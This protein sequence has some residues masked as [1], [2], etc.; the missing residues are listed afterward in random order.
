MVIREWAED[1]WRSMQ[2]GDDLL[3]WVTR[4]RGKQAPP[5][6]T[7]HP[8]PPFKRR[9]GYDHAEVTG[10]PYRD[11][12]WIKVTGSGSWEAGM[13]R[14]VSGYSPTRG[15]VSRGP[16]AWISLDTYS[17]GIAHWWART[18]P[19]LFARIALEAPA[20]ATWAWGSER[21]RKMEDPRWLPSQVKPRRRKNQKVRGHDPR[22]DWLCEGWWAIARH[23]R[24]IKIQ[25]EHWL[26]NYPASARTHARKLGWDRALRGADGGRILAAL[27]RMHN[28]GAAYRRVRA[29]KK[30]S[31]SRRPMEIL[32]TAYHLPKDKGG[33]GKPGRWKKLIAWSEF[34]GPAPERL[35]S[36][37][38]VLTATPR[39]TDGSGVVFPDWLS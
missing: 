10:W 28:S 26:G 17:V 33:Y 31:G 9:W 14:M 4:L 24:V 18:A 13:L 2:P 1:A 29:G 20:L 39:R 19:T 36:S 35:S 8:L 16:D 27:T 32:E 7:E 5:E 15:T 23:P 34:T 37:S 3:E 25:C 11:A 22:L 21:A 12:Q 38:L 6:P 30:A